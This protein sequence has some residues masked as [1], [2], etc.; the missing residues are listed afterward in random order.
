LIDS[1]IWWKRARGLTPALMLTPLLTGCTGFGLFTTPVASPLPEPVP[2]PR[3]ETAAQVDLASGLD[4]LP[5]AQQLLRSVPFGRV[6][7]FAPLL[8]AA[9]SLPVTAAGTT[10][11][12]A[13]TATA[14]AQASRQ[15]LGDLQL[16]G[17]IQGG[18]SAAA[19]VTSG[20]LSGSLKLG[21][22]GGKTP[23]LPP[24][25]RVAQISV[26]GRSLQDSPS[27]TL[28]SAGQRVTLKL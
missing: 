13:T 4:P 9:A 23:L 18:G 5:S 26:G 12:G 24:G 10:A 22:R 1:G 6:D 14:Q 2:P 20:T 25:W 3:A 28:V 16:T 21:D 19:L 17:V 27:L 8:V 11:A 7:P 15:A